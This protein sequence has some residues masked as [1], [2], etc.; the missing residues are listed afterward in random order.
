MIAVTEVQTLLYIGNQDS[1]ITKLKLVDD[2]SSDFLRGIPIQNIAVVP[3]LSKA[4][5]YALLGLLISGVY[6][7]R[8]LIFKL[9]L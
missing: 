9:L 8:F 7:N 6:E 4:F 5:R 1:D 3:I 2:S